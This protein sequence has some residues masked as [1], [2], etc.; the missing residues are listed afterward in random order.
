[1]SMYQH[2]YAEFARVKGIKPG[3]ELP[4]YEFIRW[5]Q[6]KL[7]Q[8]KRLNAHRGYLTH[9]DHEAFDEWLKGV[10]E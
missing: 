8:W 3:Q 10:Q 2:R 4:G 7:A 6:I 5:V 9:L 1:M